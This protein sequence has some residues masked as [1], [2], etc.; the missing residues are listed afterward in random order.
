MPFW[1]FFSTVT[2]VESDWVNEHCRI[3]MI[4]NDQ[5]LKGNWHKSAAIQLLSYITNTELL[6]TPI[7]IKLTSFTKNCYKH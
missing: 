4:S 5:N 7:H 6:L 3:V 2:L 1:D